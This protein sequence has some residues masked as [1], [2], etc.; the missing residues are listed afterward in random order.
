VFRLT[1]PLRSGDRLTSSPLRLVPGPEP[2]T[3]PGPGQEPAPEA[4]DDAAPAG[5]RPAPDAPAE[6]A[7]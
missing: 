2:Q 4:R 3:E 6:V 1:L 5:A 7:R